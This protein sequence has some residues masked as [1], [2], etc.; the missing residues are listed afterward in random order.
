MAAAAVRFM[1]E[2]MSFLEVSK[3]LHYCIRLYY[4]VA[5]GLLALAFDSEGLF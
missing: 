2:V 3:L 4:A 5:Y 1:A